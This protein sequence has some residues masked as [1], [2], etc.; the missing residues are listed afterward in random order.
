[1]PIDELRVGD[2]F[3]VRPGEK[4]ATDGIVIE[5]ESAVDRS[6]LTGESVPVEVTTGD[7]VAGATVSGYGVSSCGR[8]GSAPIRRWRRSHGWS[9]PLSPARLRSS[10][11]PT[12]SRLSSSRS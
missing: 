3:V 6:M 8:P 2:V 11:S 9:R 10:D 4:I 1:M 12:A 5:G 7:Q